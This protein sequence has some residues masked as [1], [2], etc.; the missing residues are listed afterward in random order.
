MFTYEAKHGDRESDTAA[1]GVKMWT[2]LFS[3][4]GDF[5]ALHYFQAAVVTWRGGGG[6][7]NNGVI[8]ITLT[9]KWISLSAHSQNSPR[10]SMQKGE[11][12]PLY[13]IDHYATH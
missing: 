8:K 10:W 11:I 13:P 12:I 7:D 1:D 3:W 6:A 9:H 2:L 5:F 4:E